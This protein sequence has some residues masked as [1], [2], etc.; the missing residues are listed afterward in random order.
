[1]K[2]TTTKLDAAADMP[3]LQHWPDQSRDFCILNSDVIRWLGRQED[4][5]QWL[6]DT[7]RGRGL[8]VYDPHTGR[9]HGRDT[10]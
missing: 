10:R 7:L 9:W 3:P 1:M 5:Q 8:I 2:R 4:I 6:F